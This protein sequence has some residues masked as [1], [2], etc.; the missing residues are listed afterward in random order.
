MMRGKE[1]DP[2]AL[3]ALVEEEGAALDD[4]EAIAADEAEFA[5]AF[6]AE[7]GREEPKA[8]AEKPAVEPAP[9]EEPVKAEAKPT[10]EEQPDQVA[11]LEQRLRAVEGRNGTLISQHKQMT[12]EIARL[13]APE[14]QEKEPTLAEMMTA[15]MAGGEKLKNLQEEFPEFAGALSEQSRIFADSVDQRLTAI[16]AE[17]G[18]R[19]TK[20]EASRMVAEARQLAQLD[21]RYPGWEETCASQQFVTWFQQQDGETK[22]LAASDD[23][24]DAMKLLEKY[25]KGLTPVEHPNTIK[26]RDRLS[27]AIPA[28]SGARGQVQKQTTEEE[29]FEAGFRSVRGK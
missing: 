6:A 12:D 14:K 9:P 15:A 28:T 5:A 20:T 18:D 29:E 17:A 2:T 21:I 7:S 27:S 4:A 10:K 26:P 8:K 11:R 25:N 16:R 3:S 22:G 13:K 23:A 24:K 19:V 1:I